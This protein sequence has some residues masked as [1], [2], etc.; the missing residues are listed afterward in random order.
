MI[1][2]FSVLASHPSP[3]FLYQWNKIPNWSYIF[4][5]AFKTE[6]TWP[7]NQQQCLYL[8][9]SSTSDYAVGM[10]LALEE[11][12]PIAKYEISVIDFTG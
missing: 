4:I 12:K 1:L 11:L 6:C 8:L 3:L 5:M 2:D 10:R 7:V 9:C